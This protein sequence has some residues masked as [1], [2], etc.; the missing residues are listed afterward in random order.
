MTLGQ[1]IF[2][3]FSVLMTVQIYLWQ[4]LTFL[5]PVG[6]FKGICASVPA[7][8]TGARK[9]GPIHTLEREKTRQTT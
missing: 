4:F 6:I 7:I 2:Q 3:H 5:G 9:K 8:L 1:A